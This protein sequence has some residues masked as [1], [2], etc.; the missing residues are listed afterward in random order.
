MDVL[1]LIIGFVIGF[2][3]ATI[4]WVILIRR[5]TIPTIKL[6]R[7]LQAKLKGRSLDNE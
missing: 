1:D 4:R 6:N 5:E 2:A 7:E 3:I